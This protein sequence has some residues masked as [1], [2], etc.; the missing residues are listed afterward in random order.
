MSGNSGE[1]RGRTNSGA[2]ILLVDDNEDLREITAMLLSNLGYE[3]VVAE[4]GA[5]AIK[6][7]EEEKSACDLLI[8]DFAMPEMSGLQLTA[9]VRSRRP[10]LK[11]LIMTGYA[12][13]PA[14]QAKLRGEALIKK[15][16]TADQLRATLAQL[17]TAAAQPRVPNG[18]GGS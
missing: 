8:V 4:S 2:T 6:L 15:P 11:V 5:A 12:D 14:F 7:L 13:D 10:D 9:R 3:V 18:D 16:F 1:P 17:L